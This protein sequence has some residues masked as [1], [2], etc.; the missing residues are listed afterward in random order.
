MSIKCYEDEYLNFGKCV[1]I[2][3][4][5]IK[6][7][8]SID[9]GPRVIWFSLKDKENVMFTDPER[10]ANDQADGYEPWYAYGGHRLWVAPELKPETYFPDNAPVK[11]TF[12]NGILTMLPEVTPFGKEMKITIKMHEDKAT[13]DLSHSIKNV[14]DKPADYAAWSITSLSK[15]GIS[16]VPMSRRA[17]GYLPNRTIALWDYADI[18]DS[19]FDITDAAIR[20]RQDVNAQKA[21]KYGINNENGFSAYAVHGQVFAKCFGPYE[22]VNYPD[23]SCNFESYTNALFLE[24]EL[25]GEMRTYAPG[26]AAELSE[27]WCIFE[28]DMDFEGD[29]DTLRD[30]LDSKVKTYIG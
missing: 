1:F 23:Y 9:I 26:E 24:S 7:G 12:E 19:R 5:I 25:I 4:G 3:N 15:G 8:V 17:S 27:T 29:L 11:Y 30:E 16:I 22:E 18:R 10:A 13:V 28:N 14:S 20:L 21:F 2:E 6:L